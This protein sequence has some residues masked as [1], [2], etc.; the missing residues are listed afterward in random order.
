MAAI[1]KGMLA[2]DH[3][4]RV[5]ELLYHEFWN[6]EL[7]ATIKNELEKAYVNLKEHVMNKECACGDRETDLNFYHWLYQEM[8]EAVAI[9]S[10]A[11][12]PVLRDELLQYFKTK[13]ESHR[14]IQELLLKKH[15]WMED[16][17]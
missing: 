5:L 17:A 8:K 3:G 6:K 14:C 16:I 4:L 10:M 12:V 2:H 1:N 7:M 15:T 13:D 11:V 9:Q